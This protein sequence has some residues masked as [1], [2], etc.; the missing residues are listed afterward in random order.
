MCRFKRK[1]ILKFEKQQFYLCNVKP[2]IRL[3]QPAPNNLD[4]HPHSKHSVHFPVGIE[5]L[6][7]CPKNS[8]DWQY[9]LRRFSPDSC[10]VFYIFFP[11]K[12]Y[13][14]QSNEDRH[15]PYK[16]QSSKDRH[17][18]L[19]LK[20]LRLSWWWALA[21]WLITDEKTFILKSYK[22]REFALPFKQRKVADV[23]DLCWCGIVLRHGVYMVWR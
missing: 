5:T 12:I 21:A 18:S 23:W 8:S 3:L 1:S 16:H 17:K 20:V 7:L 13:K 6:P 15:K 22:A 11:G 9:A 19:G 10:T 2:L 14:H 4:H